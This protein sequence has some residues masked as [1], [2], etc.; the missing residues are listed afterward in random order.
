[1]MFWGDIILHHPEL[2]KELPKDIVAL[3]WG[4]E[5]SHPFAAETKIFARSKIPFYVC[6]GT[7]TWM[8]LIGR[9]DNA[10]ANL[11]QAAGAGRRHGALG[12][13]NTDWG[14]GG[15]PQPLAVSYLPY[16]AGASLSW[17]G[18]SHDDSLLAPVLDRDIFQD[19]AGVTARAAYAL[20]L[21]HREFKYRT[22]NA[23]PF[24]ATIAAAPPR[25]RELFCRDGLKYFA[26]IPEKNI[27]AAL[28]E[29]EF[30]SSRLRRA[31]P[32]PAAQ[33]LG[34]E[35]ELAA[36]MAAQSCKFMLW[37][38]SL[39]AGH[40]DDARRQ[41]RRN[42][43]E[44]RQLQHKFTAYWPKR[45]QNNPRKYWPFLEWR[46]RDYQRGTLPFSSAQALAG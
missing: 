23:T 3:N 7:S 28:E 36:S 8:T 6:P 37:Q 22:P 44:L 43:A 35:L 33:I 17:C 46:I 12:Y 21:A 14:D 16:L 45:N 15:H 31:L 34:V 26:R 42:L 13:L 4:Y 1:M 25:L 10:L 41:A 40:T 32:S 27:R 20:G 11:R 19:R 9:H 18:A 38:Q 30:Q 24:G 2:V 29:V 39:A 5:D